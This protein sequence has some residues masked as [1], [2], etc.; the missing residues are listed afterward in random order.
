MTLANVRDEACEDG[1]TFPD[2]IFSARPE[3]DAVSGL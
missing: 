2:G 1:N 3:S